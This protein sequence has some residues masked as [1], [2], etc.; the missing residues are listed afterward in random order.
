MAVL[1]KVLES[2]GTYLKAQIRIAAI[3]IGLYIVAL[4]VTRVP[5]WLAVGLLCG[6]LNIVPHLGPVMALGLALFAKWCVTDDLLPLAYVMGAWVAIQ[7]VEG[8]IL[9]PR[10]ASRAGVNPFLSILITLAGAVF[11]G[12]IGMLLAVPV[13][14]VVLVILRAARG[15]TKIRP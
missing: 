8:F 11:F 2:L 1:S 9:S 7:I 4:A 15:R 5:W 13:T 14:I 3:V 6:L 12:P 10:A